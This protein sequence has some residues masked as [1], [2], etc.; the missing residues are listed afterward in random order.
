MINWGIIGCG[1]VTEIKSGP[2][3]NKISGSKLLAV[4]RR[5]PDLARDYAIR[6][7][8]PKYYNNANELINDPEINAVYIATPPSTHAE[9]AIKVMKAGKQVYVEKPMASSY[10]ECL[11]M[12]KV[13]IETGIPVYVAYYRR[14]L[15]GYLKVKEWIDSGLIGKPLLVNIRLF[16][17][18]GEDEKSNS[19]W[20]INPKIAGAGIFY[21]LASHQLDF[22]DYVFGPIVK[23]S[24]IAL[25][26][27]SYYTAEDT[28]TAYFQFEN[29]VIGCGS[30]CFVCDKNSSED[31]IEI[32]GESGKI[33]FS[34]YTYDP[35]MLINHQGIKYFNYKN[36]ENIQLNL[37]E[38]V[39]SSIQN[40]IECV[41][42][43]K[44]AARTNKVMEEIV[45]EYYKNIK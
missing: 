41:S 43:G 16:R 14:T 37:I 19:A 3:F 9:Y 5:N 29:G 30:W 21:D 45:K 6:H 1:N 28:V 12:N 2:A 35:I 24:G 7:N 22:L 10:A 18:A 25:N 42:T 11:E 39:V 32:F 31:T 44:S 34:T 15:P 27:S 36:P 40:K 23:V 13:S 20:R 8:V 4:M 33:I 38:N 17:P 26:N